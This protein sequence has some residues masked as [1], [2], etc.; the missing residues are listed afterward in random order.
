M[1]KREKLIKSELVDMFKTTKE[2]L[3]HY[4]NV[5]LLKPEKDEKNYRFYGYEDMAKLRQLFVLRDLGF[6]LE[7]MSAIMAKRVTHGEFKR[8]LVKQQEE[9]A[10]KIERYRLI[11]NNINSVLDL[12]G[13]ETFKISFSLRA[14]Q[15]RE[16]LLIN[17]KE[18]MGKSPKDYFDRF[19]KLIQSDWYNESII[20]SCFDYEKLSRFESLDSRVCFEVDD[21]GDSLKELLKNFDDASLKTFEAGLYVSVFYAFRQGETVHLKDVKKEIDAYIEANDLL[22]E[23]TQVLEFEHLE[24][25]MLMDG[26]EELYEIQVKVKKRSV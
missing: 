16:F 3:R 6:Q 19:E 24:L 7:D 18:I 25:S 15:R 10:K 4:E 11:Q 5:G 1:T 22:M 2:A 14:F 23:E 17:A 20:A 21:Q 8:L 26:Q 12:V 13:D 9:L